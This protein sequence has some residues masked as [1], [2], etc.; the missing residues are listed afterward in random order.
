MSESIKATRYPRRAMDIPIF[1]A[2]VVFPT[3]PFPD[4]ITIVRGVI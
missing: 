4:V 2:V 1:A 3:P